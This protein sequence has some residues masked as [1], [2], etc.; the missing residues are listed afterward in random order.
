VV[1][2][3]LV[4]VPIE[5]IDAELLA[6]PLASRPAFSAALVTLSPRM[7]D[8]TAA[9]WRDT[10]RDLL[11][12]FP[13]MSID[14][15]NARRDHQW[16]GVRP[17]LLPAV[18]LAEMLSNAA[19][20]V[21]NAESGSAR[22]MRCAER[23][24]AEQRRLWRWITF[25]LPADLLLAGVGAPSD[26][27]DTV[28][29]ALKMRLASEGLAET[30][31]HLKAAM[32]F[33][34]LWGSL[35]SVLAETGARP[36]MLRSPGADWDEGRALAPMLLQCAMA[37][38]VLAAFLARGRSASSDLRGYLR[39]LALPRLQARFGTLQAMNLW[40]AVANLAAGR[41]A[42]AA[43]FAGDR[44]LYAL[45][46]GPRFKSRPVAPDPDRMAE[47]DPMV[48][49]F[50]RGSLQHAPADFRFTS[51]AF[52]YLR[53]SG[54]DDLLFARVF[55]Q[56]VRGRV[57]FYRH[58][59]QRPMV[60]GLQWFIRSYGRLSTP[61]R[62]LTLRSFVHR[63][64]R[65]SGPGLRSLEGRLSPDDRF[66]DLYRTMHDIDMARSDIGVEFGIVFHFSRMRG[67]GA[68]AGLPEAWG[69][70]GH[71][72][73]AARRC[74][75][76]G[77]R[78]SGYYRSVRKGAVNLAALLHAY[79]RS[80]EIVRGVDLCT[81]E[82]G[83]PLWVL[84]PLLAH[85]L[86]A[87]REASAWLGRTTGESVP[88][89]G[90]TVHAGEDFVHLIGGIR[91]VAEAVDLLELGEGARLGH[92]VAL[93]V[94]VK[95]WCAGS[96]LLRVPRGERLLDLLWAWQMA[97]QLS[98]AKR[99]WLAV[100]E[101]EICR[102]GD[103]IFGQAVTPQL[104]SRWWLLLHDARALR[105]TGFPDGPVRLDEQWLQVQGTDRDALRLLQAWLTSPAV[106]ARSQ[107]LELV[108]TGK[109]VEQLQALQDQVRRNIAGRGLVVEVN[110][111]SNLLIGHFVDLTAHPLWRIAPPP[112]A[113]DS[114]APIR[115][116]IGSDD[117]ITFATTLPEEYQL[118]ADALAS[119]GVL[120]PDVDHWLDAARNCGLLSRFTVRHS[121][122][123]LLKNVRLG[124]APALE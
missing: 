121:G 90:V 108:D 115:V 62:A 30:H 16:F 50:G 113:A 91:R 60:P 21:V 18:P 101:R 111:S 32:T 2:T 86:R 74:N 51:A 105:C 52:A 97:P 53:D 38:Q 12:R 100:V 117:P 22:P 7:L 119:A 42:T 43:T 104:L 1:P 57:A 106:F 3:R 71:D 68:G 35:M 15:L 70:G 59:V 102:L 4:G 61:R 118:V 99:G 66:V 87:G 24:E 47:A 23:S 37:R 9:L 39:D 94:D 26:A 27:L 44:H 64:H 92:A 48:E 123:P 103:A 114:A 49:W 54:R 75:P 81:D 110:P 6:A 73:P 84:K 122:R 13:G 17:A 41:A 58:V 93:G 109:D 112:G 63:A 80:L 33:G 14:E 65:I 78:Y 56:S 19:R 45:L 20:R 116:A 69:M 34:D 40:R 29:Q 95:A 85:V 88:P 31:L 25:S 82:L 107:E 72:D 8:G 46:I 77:Y 79:P 36:E 5:H 11:G 96:T 98:D 120:A 10:E 28:S 83:V 55:W 89:L 124:P 76:S 67:G